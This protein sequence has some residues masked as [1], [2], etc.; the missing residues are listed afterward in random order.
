ML[1][2]HLSRNKTTIGMYNAAVLD[3]LKPGMVLINCARGSMVD[4]VA[5]KER[6]ESGHISGAAFDVFHVEPANGNPLLDVPNFYGSPHIGA[7]TRDSWSAMLRS[8]M[9]GIE[10]AYRQ[11]PGVYPYD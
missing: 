4:E 2:I 10:H 3:K 7:T 6:L 1:T 5:L 11:E 9:H 8:G